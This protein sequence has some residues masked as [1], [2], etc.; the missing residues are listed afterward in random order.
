MGTV[1]CGVGAGKK[2]TSTE[3]K[4]TRILADACKGCFDWVPSVTPRLTGLC[5]GL[6]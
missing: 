2:E 4:S 1:V 5:Y 6:W 3:G